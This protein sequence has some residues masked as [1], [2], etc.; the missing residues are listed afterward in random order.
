MTATWLA[1]A[2]RA[3]GL[4]VIEEPGWSSR[5]TGGRFDPIGVLCHHTAGAATGDLPSLRVVRDGRTGLSGP[6]AQLMLSRSGVYHVI[7]AGRANHA[8]AGSARWVPGNDGNRH[9]CGIEAESVGSRD[10]WTPAQRVAYPQG[11]A[12]LCRWMGVRSNRVLAH[13]EWAP[14]RKIDP[15]FWD[16]DAMRAEVDRLLSGATTSTTPSR[17]PRE[18]EPMAIIPISTDD[19]GRFHEAAMIEVG[20]DFGGRGAITLGSTWGTSEVTVTALNHRQGVIRQ[21]PAIRLGNNGFWAQELPEGTRIVTVEGSVQG[22][23][24]RLA[25]SLHTRAPQ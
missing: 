4:R 7:A 19:Q 20:S 14:D 8:G 16:M 6:L 5:G 13:R 22:V 24:T 9:L 18:D 3:G 25:A 17:P 12:A 15:A 11:V 2:L 21:W 10:D 1:A 23:G